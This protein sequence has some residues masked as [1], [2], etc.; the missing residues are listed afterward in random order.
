[1]VNLLDNH[2][3]PRLL[4]SMP[5]PLHDPDTQRR[6]HLA[7]AALLTLPG[8][9][10]IYY[11]NEI[12]MNGGADPWNRRF[13]PEWAFSAAERSVENRP[14]YVKNPQKAWA[15]TQNLLKIRNSNKALQLGE[16][17]E[18]WRQNGPSNP[19]VW[20]FAR[21]WDPANDG[22][23]GALGSTDA[24]GAAANQRVMVVFNNGLRPLDA[25][26][27]IPVGHVFEDD[28]ELVDLLGEVPAFQANVDDGQLA[29]FLPAQSVVI[30]S[31]K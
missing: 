19:N 21:V 18:L 1:M 3:V 8:I 31:P 6:Y 14:G 13:M 25:P 15:L 12:G 23:D 26:L 5:K 30:L 17:V 9:P 4:E 29:V 20:A 28:V 2:D 7:M 24:S 27:K 16:Y 10:Q 11:G 22:Q